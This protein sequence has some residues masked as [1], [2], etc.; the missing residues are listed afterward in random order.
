M[1]P[2]DAATKPTVDT[3]V[4]AAISAGLNRDDLLVGIDRKAFPGL[5]GGFGS[6]EL[7]LGWDLR[8]LAADPAAACRWC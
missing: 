3:L 4:A 1:E 6:A 8:A 5:G 7:V 2:M